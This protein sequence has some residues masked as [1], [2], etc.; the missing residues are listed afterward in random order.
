M[1][2]L[3]YFWVHFIYERVSFLST[4]YAQVGAS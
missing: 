3:L 1:S 4:S 2:S